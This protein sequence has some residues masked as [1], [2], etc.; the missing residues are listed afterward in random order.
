[1]CDCNRSR[2]KFLK[3]AAVVA[4]GGAMGGVVGCGAPSAR[5][6]LEGGQGRTLE[7]PLAEAP[8]LQQVGGVVSTPVRPGGSR[9]LLV[10][11]SLT[12]VIAV[13]PV[14]PH[15]GC[16]VNY[17]GE[18]DANCFV[19]PCHGSAFGIEGDLRRGPATEGLTRFPTLM[20]DDKVTVSL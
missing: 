8:A 11:R 1:M 13:S 15:Q 6:L 16:I 5:Y 18:M 7:L 12:E 17:T 10:R 2:R 9:I 20:V 4:A 14:C 3:R 19:C